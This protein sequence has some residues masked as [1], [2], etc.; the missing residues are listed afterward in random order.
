MC[1]GKGLSQNEVRMNRKI[2]SIL[3][4]IISAEGSL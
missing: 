2:V 4:P 3:T 1:F